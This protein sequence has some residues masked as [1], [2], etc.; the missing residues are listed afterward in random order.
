MSSNYTKFDCEGLKA[1]KLLFKYVISTL[2]GS[3]RS[4]SEVTLSM[5]E[6]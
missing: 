2:F 6:S 5:V 3:W 1:L 4:S